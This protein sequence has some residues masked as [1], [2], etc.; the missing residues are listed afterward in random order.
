[1][2]WARDAD[3]FHY[4]QQSKLSQIMLTTPPLKKRWS[5]QDSLILATALENGC[6]IVYSE[7]M[8]HNHILENRLTIINPFGG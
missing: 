4:H 3:R 6:D 1:L 5:C 2:K 7:D 8:Q